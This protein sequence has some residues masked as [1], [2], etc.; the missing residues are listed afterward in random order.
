MQVF[1]VVHRCSIARQ[2]PVRITAFI[3]GVVPGLNVSPFVQ[4]HRK[5][6]FRT[7]T[8][9]H[10]HGVRKLRRIAGSHQ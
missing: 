4:A 7:L 2:M 9:Q 5:E 10:L 6:F 3:S 8:Q 1:N